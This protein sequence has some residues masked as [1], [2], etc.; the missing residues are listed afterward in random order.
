MT[1]EEWL[2]ASDPL[3]MLKLLR[4]IRSGRKQCLFYLA[5]C[6]RLLNVLADGRCQTALAVVER[7]ADDEAKSEELLSAAEA[8]V[9]AWRYGSDEYAPIAVTCGY[10]LLKDN[11]ESPCGPVTDEEPIIMTHSVIE[12]FAYDGRWPDGS[13]E[14]LP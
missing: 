5:C 1:E 11:K 13:E 10:A 2:K 7:Y 3:P 8:V 14:A 6:S 4:D 12:Q 9:S